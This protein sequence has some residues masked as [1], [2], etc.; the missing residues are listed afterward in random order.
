MTGPINRSVKSVAQRLLFLTA[1]GLVVGCEG[2]AEQPETISYLDSTP[3]VS[4]NTFDRYNDLSVVPPVSENLSISYQFE[5]R[6]DERGETV[7]GVSGPVWFY[8]ERTAAVPEAFVQVSLIPSASVASG[9]AVSADDDGARQINETVRLGALDYVSEL[10]CVNVG[11]L[12]GLRPGLAGFVRHIAD[13]GFGV[14]GELFIRSY[15]AERAGL[16]GRHVS[17]VFLRDVTRLG[18]TCSELGDLFSPEALVE[19]AVDALK[20]EASRSFE[21]VQ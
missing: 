11:E 6:S 14:S 8:V 7:A 9:S 5:L 2:I 19:D 1:L 12:A 17:V 21:V 4:G 18:H 16:D 3:A 15:Q 20:E 13:K 10:H